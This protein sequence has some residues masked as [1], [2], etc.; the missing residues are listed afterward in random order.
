MPN[1]FLN[2]MGKAGTQASFQDIFNEGIDSRLS[3]QDD[4]FFI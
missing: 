4:V 1:N 2:E 3:S